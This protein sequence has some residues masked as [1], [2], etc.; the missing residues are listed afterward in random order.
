MMNDDGDIIISEDEYL[1]ICR[2][3]DLKVAYRADF[4]EL[5][6]L[7]AEIQYCEP[8]VDQCRHRLIQGMVGSVH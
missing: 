8:L 7:K 1:E 2:L 3:K 6:Q 5:K 4:E